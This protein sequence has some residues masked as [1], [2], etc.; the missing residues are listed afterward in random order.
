M[1][2]ELLGRWVLS[3]PKCIHIRAGQRALAEAVDRWLA[4]AG[5]IFV[6]D[7]PYDAAAYALTCAHD[8]PD[9]AAVGIDWL[10]DAE[11]TLLRRLRETW[12]GIVLLVYGAEV[13]RA[14]ADSHLTRVCRGGELAEWTARSPAA[15]LEA[16]RRAER[17]G[18]RGSRPELSGRNMTATAA[19]ELQGLDRFPPRRSELVVSPPPPLRNARERKLSEAW[20]DLTPEEIRT[21][22]GPSR[23]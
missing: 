23:P 12:P 14:R 6:C 19:P 4:D 17:P 21:L 18:A 1:G 7:S 10:D 8:M 20:P 5:P 3:A 2:P 11:L 9:L 15:A 16:I 13:S 22:L